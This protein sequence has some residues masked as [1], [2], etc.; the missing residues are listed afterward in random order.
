MET[1][2]EVKFLLLDRETIRQRI[3][4]SG[5][6]S[7][8]R[9]FESNIRFDTPGEDLYRSGALL[10]LRQ[11]HRA[12]LTHKSRSVEK[13]PEFKVHRELEVV[14]SDH[15]TMRRILEALGFK[16]VQWYEKYRETFHFDR[17]VIC[18]DTMPFGEFIEIEGEKET[19][20]DL[21]KQLSLNWENRILLNYL[22][23]FKR[24]GEKLRLPF[25]DLT[26]H[27]F[28]TVTQDIASALKEISLR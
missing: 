17:A 19:I 16:A 12:I 14:V 23:I 9:V 22:E 8:G 10:R 7:D 5:V 28:S 20:R 1:E 6:P 2:I 27:H 18:L 26:F 24:L 13:D 25:K 11:D 15:D 3:L 4:A 21:A